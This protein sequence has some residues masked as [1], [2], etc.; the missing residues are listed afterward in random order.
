MDDIAEVLDAL[1]HIDPVSLDYKEWSN[2]GMA[3]KDAGCDCSVWDNWS[4][5]DVERY[6]ESG[7]DSCAAKWKT[8]DNDKP[9]KVTKATIFK[10]AKAAG[11]HAG[12]A[13]GWNDRVTVATAPTIDVA[14]VTKASVK[15]KDVGEDIVP[16][17]E[18][19]S[20]RQEVYDYLQALFE[21]NEHVGYVTNDVEF[22]SDGKG[23]GSWK[24]TGS[25]TYF[26]T[27]GQI[28]KELMRKKDGEYANKAFDWVLES[29]PPEGGAF[30]RINPLDGNGPSDKN[31]TA[32]RHALIESDTLPQGKQ[33][34][35]IRAMKLPV[36][37]V[38][39]SGHKSVHG[40][41]RVDAKDAT[42]YKERV[43]ALYDYC[44]D[45]GFIC[46]EQNRNPSRLSRIPGVQRGEH[47]QR[48]I[49][50]TWDHYES[51]DEWQDWVVEEATGLPDIKSAADITELP[52]LAPQLIYG[53]L[54]EGQK[55]MLIGPS[56]AGKSFA[57]IELAIA[58]CKG[59]E[60][61]GH[62]CA[63]GKVLYVNFEIQDASF[64]HRIDDVYRAMAAEH[65]TEVQGIH[66][67]KDLDFWCLRG[68]AARLDKLVPML[69]RK[70]KDRDYKLVI[71]DPIYKVL[72]G[73][74]NSASDMAEF[75]NQFDV[76]ATSLHCAVFYAHHYAKGKAGERAA[77][78]RA[79]GSGVFARD[80]D[81]M[82]DM[83]PLVIPAEERD[84]LKY[85]T[86]GDDGNMH[87][88]HGRAYRLNY[89]LREFE[90]PLPRDIVF[91]WPVHE[92]RY[93]LDNFKEEGSQAARSEAGN[94]TRANKA[95]ADWDAKNEV[96]AAALEGM[97][98]TGTEPKKAAVRSYL[99]LNLA[100]S[101]KAAGWTDNIFNECFKPSSAA[102]DG[103]KRSDFIAVSDANGATLIR[104]RN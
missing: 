65:G 9:D 11:W 61:L 88:R 48:L 8:F 85:E 1:S 81:A 63:R 102:K 16:D 94:R 10:M 34:A 59:W 54:R 45:A 72:T 46:D 15:A 49:P 99:H 22:V 62:K 95:D 47:W 68:H 89:T 2:I 17:G 90:S 42:Q 96:I 103:Y 64:M 14:P 18:P 37:A 75:T 44:R 33:L 87:E 97:T 41:V 53:V 70:A 58:I 69:Q 21:P 71:I 23:G 83:C 24:P 3:L 19:T 25:G 43:Q 66:E 52:N 73:D 13:Y 84:C 50:I 77:V 104:A 39:S 4:K 92:V 7:S 36:V 55:G 60:W 74:E 51:W 29:Y 40:I 20:W 56:K 78:D 101:Y 6:H 76:I 79:S 30:I 31:V 100:Q 12:K 5:R 57:L 67:L 28:C 93:D 27:Q 86:D 35:L 80:P 98:K 26:K 38:V 32:Y 91:K 82:I